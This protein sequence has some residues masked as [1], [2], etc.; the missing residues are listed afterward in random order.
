MGV[1]SR[2]YRISF[3]STLAATR[4]R[5]LPGATGV[6][7]MYHEV[8]PDE[9]ELPVWTIVREA[10]FRWQ[11]QF[12]QVHFDV[13]SIDQALA[14]IAGRVVA[15]RPFAV[16]TFDDG[17][18]GNLEVVLPIMV[19]MGLPFLVYVATEKV[20]AGGLFWHDQVI[21]LLQLR[22]DVD[23][24]LQIQGQERR[25]QISSKASAARRWESM[26]QLLCCL[27]QMSVDER[28]ANVE[29]LLV[30]SEGTAP[31]LA[32]LDEKGVQ[33]LAASDCVTIGSHTHGHELLDQISP[34]AVKKTLCLADRHIARI[35]GRAPGHFA[36][37]NGNYN[38][39]VLALIESA[40]YQ[41]AA[42]T[43]TGFWTGQTPRLQVPR[44]AIG[45]FETRSLFMA[46]VSGA[47]G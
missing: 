7:L 13:V 45:R 44:L 18:R 26:E 46:R 38:P 47:L 12:L 28:M 36:Y 15:P 23:A 17:Y 25:L 21:A 32:M 3:P 14:R 5:A 1:K 34:D 4:I 41:S 33:R 27:K 16:V 31:A 37:P 22:R 8:L 40:G 35:T 2:L 24:V 9:I 42:T 19:T 11:M 29:R 39:A 20:V 6:V 30:Q 43:R 10:E